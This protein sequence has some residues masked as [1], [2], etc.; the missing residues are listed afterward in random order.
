[1]INTILNL[2][3]GL[4]PFAI[5]PGCDTRD[6]KMTLALGFALILGL[7]GIY[8]GGLKPIKNKWLLSF[9]GF[10]LVSIFLAPKIKII[11]YDVEVESFWVWQ[12]FSY[13]LIFF[14]MYLSVLS[15]NFTDKE[16]INTLKIMAWAGFLMAIYALLQ[17]LGCDQ[18]FE[19]SK[20]NT[21]IAGVPSRLVV[22]TMGQPTLLAPF[23]AMIVPITLYLKRYWMAGVIG[24]VVFLTQS[25]TA[26][27]AMILSI[28]LL[29]SLQTKR[30]FILFIIFLFLLSG[31]FFTYG[32]KKYINDSGRFA[33]WSQAAKDLNTPFYKEQNI[34]Y[35]LTGF[36]AGSF[37]YI[38]HMKHFNKIG[39]QW[40]QAHNEYLEVLYT[41]GI[42]GVFLFM[43]ALF[44]LLN[45]YFFTD[46][47]SKYLLASFACIAICAA[48][49]F[50]LQLGCIAFYS[51]TILGLLAQ[52]GNL[53]F[54]S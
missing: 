8:N 44:T 39:N 14:L 12:T 21:D 2:G 4:I 24:L 5:W 6:P 31:V 7:I 45:P 19:V 1:M 33:T 28:G 17:F 25:T 22:G 10:V 36:G 26:I 18:F 3:L 50:V 48:G 35:P 49:T 23:L 43:M 51:V 41:T 11:F 30:R 54:K 53:E 42:I 32:G 29:I 47:L 27:L 38:Y 52:G 13:I 20:I 46:R 9:I 34:K 37:K 40:L 15:Q 16:K